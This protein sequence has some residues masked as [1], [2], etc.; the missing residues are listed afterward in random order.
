MELVILGI[1]IGVASCA[2]G[3]A[4]GFHFLIRTMEARQFDDWSD[5]TF[6]ER[7]NRGSKDGKDN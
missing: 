4:I 2:V 3:V 1:I 7:A 5:P 6:L